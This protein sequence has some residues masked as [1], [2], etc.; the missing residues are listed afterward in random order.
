MT[1]IYREIELEAVPLDAWATL[2]DSRNLA[3]V[4]AGVLVEVTLDG[5]VR[6][7]TFANGNVVRERIVAIDDE[8][9]RIAYAAMG[10]H[11]EHHHASMQIVPDSHGRCQ[12]VWISDFLPDALQTAIE[13]LVDAGCA[14]L[15]R[16][17][18]TPAG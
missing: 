6:T 17:L 18:G 11:F 4:F 1:S 3:D 15:K 10:G 7:V 12:F 16:S 8:R 2:R 13:P 14:A 5:D 9:M